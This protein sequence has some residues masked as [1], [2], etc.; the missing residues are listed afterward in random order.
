MDENLFNANQLFEKYIQE[1]NKVPE[2]PEDEEKILFKKISEGDEKA[3]ERIAKSYLKLVVNIA[4]VLHKNVPFIS[5]LDLISEGNIGLLKAIDKYDVSK[6]IKFSTY[7]AWW[8][9]QRIK[10]ALN[11]NASLIKIPSHIDDILRCFFKVLNKNKAIGTDEK[12]KAAELVGMDFNKIEECLDRGRNSISL[13]YSDKE[14]ATLEEYIENKKS[15]DPQTIY[16]RRELFENLVKWLNIL[17]DKERKVI[18]LR[19]GLTDENPK[20]LEEIGEMMNL[21]RE[22][23]RQIEEN[24]LNKLRFYLIKVKHIFF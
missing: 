12:I 10:R 11:R 14:N 24:A 4:K 19:Y 6:G 9:K 8:I 3:K 5:I 16:E 13:N 2:L 17:T 15:I 1:I 18:L 21:T 20:T 22:R 7:A 23:I